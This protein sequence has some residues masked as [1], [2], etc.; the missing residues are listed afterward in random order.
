MKQYLLGVVLVLGLFF[1]GCSK[2]YHSMRVPL[3]NNENNTLISV[4]F[5]PT[6]PS[7]MA[8]YGAFELTIFNKTDKEME[9]NWNKT[10]FLDGNQAKGGFIL[11]DGSYRDMDMNKLPDIIF[12]NSSFHKIIYPKA[13]YRYDKTIGWYHA[14]TGVGK[15]G[16]YLSISLDGKEIKHKE[17]VDIQEK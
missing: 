4:E 12:P 10:Y 9:L 8:G 5:L 17:I 1:T 11:E 3:E 2:T 14:G 6:H 16:I 15:Q 13:Y 7:M